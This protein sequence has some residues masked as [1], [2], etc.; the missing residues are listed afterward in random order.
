[1]S[2]PLKPQVGDRVSDGFQNG[3]VVG[4]APGC[5]HV[6]WDHWLDGSFEAVGHH[7]LRPAE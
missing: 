5:V 1:M 3:T 6:N 2:G 4:L 7:V